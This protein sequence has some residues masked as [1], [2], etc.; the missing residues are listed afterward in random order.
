[1]NVDLSPLNIVILKLEWCN[2]SL[3]VFSAVSFHQPYVAES[4][5]CFPPLIL[6]HR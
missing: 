3:L 1:M 4:E 2:R 6:D 5:L